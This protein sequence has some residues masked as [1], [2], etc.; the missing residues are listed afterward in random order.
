ML[1]LLIRAARPLSRVARAF[2]G[3]RARAPTT[4][5]VAVVERAPAARNIIQ[6]LL[7]LLAPYP[8]PL[9]CSIVYSLAGH[10]LGHKTQTIGVPAATK[11]RH[12]YPQAVL[13]DPGAHKF[14]AG[15][16]RLTCPR[17]WELNFMSRERFEILATF[18]VVVTTQVPAP[19]R[20]RRRVGGRGRGP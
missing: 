15:L 3:W 18:D 17:A 20:G 10:Q 6:G 7:S 1:L 11:C 14:G 5:E 4:A 2:N 8:T 9:I 16:L 13:Q 12:G 19:L